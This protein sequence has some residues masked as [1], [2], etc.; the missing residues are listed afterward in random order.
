M[1]LFVLVEKTSYC[2]DFKRLECTTKLNVPNDKIIR[3][4]E[5]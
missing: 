4:K 5:K 2:S 1:V 3:D